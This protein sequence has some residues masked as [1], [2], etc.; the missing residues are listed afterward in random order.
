MCCTERAAQAELAVSALNREDNVVFGGDMSWDDK[1]DLP[2]PLLDGW[3]DASFKLGLGYGSAN[4]Y[5]E[6]WNRVPVKAAARLKL[7]S[8]M[9][10]RAFTQRRSYRTVSCASSVT[11]SSKA[12]N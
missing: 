2:F 11:T 3:V 5:D 10:E 6:L 7:G 8:S 4:A 9:G 1:V 12:W